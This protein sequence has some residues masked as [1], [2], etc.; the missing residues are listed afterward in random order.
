M[1][2]TQNFFVLALND[3]LVWSSYFNM[4]RKIYNFITKNMERFSEYEGWATLD[5]EQSNYVTFYGIKTNCTIS[6]KFQSSK[7]ELYC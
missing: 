2:N 5:T 7:T 1:C 6:V 4:T 3:L